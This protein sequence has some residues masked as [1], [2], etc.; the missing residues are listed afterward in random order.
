MKLIHEIG[1]G[2]FGVVFKAKLTVEK[3]HHEFVAVKLLK[4]NL[5]ISYY[6]NWELTVFIFRWMF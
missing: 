1:K 6:F 3:D 5:N 4:G 2:Q